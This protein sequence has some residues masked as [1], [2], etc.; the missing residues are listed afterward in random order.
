MGLVRLIAIQPPRLELPDELKEKIAK[1]LKASILD[2]IKNQRQADGSPLKAN[3]QRYADYKQR[4]G[5]TWKGS[6]L[7]LVAKEH[8]FTR[9]ELWSAEWEGDGLALKLIIE[10]TAGEDTARISLSV[11]ERGY[12]GWFAAP[13]ADIEAALALV[14]KWI[15]DSIKNAVAKAGT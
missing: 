12:T 13:T 10:P 4:A 7:A 6:V 5:M 15:V 2:N 3:S 14:R 1:L 11:Q 9:P 8:R